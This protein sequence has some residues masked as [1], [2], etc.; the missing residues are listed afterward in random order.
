MRNP[1]QPLHPAAQMRVAGPRVDPGLPAAALAIGADYRLVV[2]SGQ[3]AV[4]SDDRFG[5]LR[6]GGDCPDIKGRAFD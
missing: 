2:F 1:I 4:L 6:A 5:D 3:R